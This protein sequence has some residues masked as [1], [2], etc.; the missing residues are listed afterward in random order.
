M[1]AA[2]QPSL[3]L[4]A[5][6]GGKTATPSI[7]LNDAQDAVAEEFLCWLGQGEPKLQ[8]LR[9]YAGTGKTTMLRVALERAWD[10][11]LIIGDVVG[12]APTHQAV[13]VMGKALEGSGVIE[14]ITAHSLL[15]LRP[16]K[17]KFEKEDQA[18]LDSLLAT[19]SEDRNSDD[20]ALIDS[21]QVKRNKADEGHQDFVSRKLKTGIESIRLLLVD[22]C[23]MIDS[24]M[25]GL[26]AQLITNPQLNPN[27]QILFIGDPAQLPPIQ[28]RQSK[29]FDLPTF[30][31]LTKVVRYT[32]SILD[33]CNEVR[34][35]P[36]YEW[37]HRR[38]PEDETMMILPSYEVMDQIKSLYEGG[39]SIRFVAAT[40]KRVTELNYQIRSLLHDDS[41]QLFYEPGDV[42]LTLNAVQR[43]THGAYDIACQGRKAAL[44]A[45]T[46][47]LIE[48]GKPCVPGDYVSC[49][50]NNGARL[51]EQSFNF[52]SA[53]GTDFE[54]LIY[55]YRYYDS[56]DSFG[57]F[58][59]L[60]LINP[61]QWAQWIKERDLL[62]KR[63]RTTQS[64]GKS[65]KTSRGQEGETAKAVWAEFG[66]K[67]WFRW[68]NGSSITQ[69]EYQGIKGRLWSDYYALLGFAD[70]ASY[71]YASTAHRVQGV[72]LDIVVVDMQSIVTPKRAW[73]K[74]DA[75]W[76][77][78][79]L[80]YTAAT[81]ARQQLIFMV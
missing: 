67:D 20:L 37:L 49:G 48:L 41:K 16:E 10:R 81:R 28:E 66:M 61:E 32:G 29:T 27:L 47:S 46:S 57:Q 68:D 19:P 51:T 54:R 24:Y 2:L 55:R 14:C 13:K 59:A 30:K 75:I 53:L 3:R 17:V 70:Q 63:A 79:K 43:E 71:S 21:L 26:F 34:V 50:P 39:E 1:T 9:G 56:G 76:D 12:C 25:F 22:E 64:R 58:P 5:I 73:Q 31:E 40:N 45:H 23:S 38:V 80:L 18:L 11:G 72:T 60:C 77:T 7:R 8:T 65:K 35:D 69:Q 44:E 62:L 15:G 36:D 6:S 74:D 4:A 33:Y 42:I 52:T 78:R